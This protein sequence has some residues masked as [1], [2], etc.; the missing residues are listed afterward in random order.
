MKIGLIP[1]IALLTSCSH[2]DV[3]RW[4]IFEDSDCIPE[5]LEK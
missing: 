4:S 2:T 5:V 1:I 3:D